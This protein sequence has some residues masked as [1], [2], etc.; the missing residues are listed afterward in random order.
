MKGPYT[1]ET[2]TVATTEQAVHQ[3][4][5]H[6][7]PIVLLHDSDDEDAKIDLDVNTSCASRSQGH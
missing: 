3:L 6:V 5:E 2:T 1:F 4:W 7:L